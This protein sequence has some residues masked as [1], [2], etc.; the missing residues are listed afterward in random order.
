MLL[1][2]AMSVA[3]GMLVLA[4]CRKYS[5]PAIVFL[6]LSGVLLGPQCVGLVQPASLG[7]VLPALVSL[8]VGLILFEGGLTLDVAGYRTVPRVIRRLL[9]LGVMVT[10]LGTASLVYLLYGHDL[11]FCLF[12]G[13]LVIVTGPTVIIPLLK[14]IKPVPAIQHILHWE[15]VLIDPIGVIIAF[16]AFELYLHESGRG[17][18]TGFMLSIA[19]GV[20]VGFVGGG[21]LFLMLRHAWFPADMRNG[22]ILATAIGIF[23]LAE[24]LASEAGVLAVT[25]AGFVTALSR[26]PELRTV[27]QFK[28]EI[29]DLLIGTLFVLLAARLDF[30][31]F[32]AFGLQGACLVAGV[33]FILRPLSIISCTQRSG[34]GWREKLFLG[35]VAPRGIVAASMASV[36]GLQLHS[37]GR[38]EQAVFVETFVFAVIMATVLLQ[39]FTAAPLARWL[40]LRRRPADGWMVVGAHRLGRQVAGFLCGRVTPNVFLVDT[41][42]AAVTAAQEEGLVAVQADARDLEGLGP[43]A[44]QRNVGHVLAMT[45]NEDLNEVICQRWAESLPPEHLFRWAS[46]AEAP[47]VPHSRSHGQPVLCHL[48]KPSLISAELDGH[49]AWVADM[50]PTAMPAAG[51]CL[52][53]ADVRV[54][55]SAPGRGAG[56]RVPGARCLVLQRRAQYLP[57]S[58]REDLVF[59]DQAGETMT[60]VIGTMVARLAACFPVLPKAD[61]LDAL[62]RVE[63]IQPSTVGNGLAIPHA[64]SP[65]LDRSVCAVARLASGVKVQA[66]DGQPVRWVF[67]LVGPANDPTS[68][69]AILAEIGM[70]AADAERCR[71]LDRVQT[72]RDFVALIR[73]WG[74]PSVAGT[75][76][77]LTPS[78]ASPPTP[79]LPRMGES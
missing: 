66:P 5:L 34:L 36:F 23:G 74:D 14:R 76:A 2:I 15:G 13:S 67:L 4:M 3:A 47:G 18:V 56:R 12:A 22:M 54:H 28:G 7:A 78:G 48:P 26:C 1:S 55:F 21:L 69:L 19:S 52:L 16:S 39:G 25:I 35:W 72:P 17:A 73:A 77:A 68:H 58:I 75:D 57:Q 44:E 33:I 6:L 42:A 30:S 38:P 37:A 41:N 51:D 11:V 45:D 71:A 64:Y 62:M 32:R 20:A 10:W 29:S 49:D 59:L 50:A 24:A 9:T 53:W 8:A 70:L 31:Q 40:R 27:R 60:A 61:L 65:Q 46:R 63:A 79:A 43:E